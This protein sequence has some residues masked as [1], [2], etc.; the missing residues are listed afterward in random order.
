MTSFRSKITLG[1]LGIAAMV[2]LAACTSSGELPGTTWRVT[3]LGDAGV[4]ADAVITLGFVDDSNVEGETG[5]NSFF[6]SYTTDGDNISIGPLASTL[7]A[8]VPPARAAMEQAYVAALETATTYDIGGDTLTLFGPNGRQLVEA[9]RFD[10]ILQGSSWEVLSYNNGN[11]AVVSVLLGTEISLVFGENDEVSGVACNNYNG[12]YEA[13]DQRISIGPFATTRK[14]CP[15]PE[16]TMEQEGLYLTALE[17]SAV[18][19]IRGE[20]LELRDGNGSL[21]VSALPGR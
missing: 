4:V 2:I 18:W 11:Q 19:Q 9:E 8:C 6:G 12:P 21:Q 7:A 16:G 3:S 5:C 10:P 17:A 14:A 15:E 13:E 1:G 20:M